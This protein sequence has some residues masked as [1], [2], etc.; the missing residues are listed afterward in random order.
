[1]GKAFIYYWLMPCLVHVQYKLL[2]KKQVSE[3]KKIEPFPVEKS[4]SSRGK[5]IK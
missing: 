5:K 2:H 4:P 1:M 3:R